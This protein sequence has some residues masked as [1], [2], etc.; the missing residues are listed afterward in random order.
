[1]LATNTPS[2]SG[3]TNDSV[4]VTL[5]NTVGAPVK[6]VGTT[7]VVLSDTGSGFFSTATGGAAGNQTYN[8]GI[9][10]GNTTGTAY[11]GGETTGPD[12]ISAVNGTTLWGTQALTIVSGT[13]T[14]VSI[15]P[16]T[17]TP[18]VSAT[19][20]TTLS[21]QLE[22][23]YGN[24]ATSASPITLALTAGSGFFSTTS[25]TSGSATINVTF[26]SGA[27]AATAYFGDQTSGGD[28]IT[29]KN[30]TTTWATS[31]VTLAPGTAT[32]VLVTLAPTNPALHTTTNVTVS[33]QLEDQF[34]NAVPLAGVGFTL[35]NSGAGFFSK[36]TGNAGTPTLTLSGNGAGGVTNASGAATA[37]FGDDTTQSVT[38]TATGTGTYTGISSASLPLND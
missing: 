23:Q 16:S 25:G 12:T 36:T 34:G 38:V 35:T 6:S 19:T 37:A 2:V 31:A 32:K 18:A 1:V 30:G 3:T 24:L 29:A 28:T 27:G 9:T 22:D 33:L 21:F 13:P 26:A 11:F 7:T 20:N 10:N 5:E 17:T 8:L 15:T 14:Q 4:T